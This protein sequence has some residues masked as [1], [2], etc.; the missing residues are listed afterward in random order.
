M[1]LVLMDD[2]IMHCELYL[3]CSGD[4]LNMRMQADNFLW[5][6]RLDVNEV[7]HRSM[8]NLLAKIDKKGTNFEQ[9]SVS[10]DS[11]VVRQE[12]CSQHC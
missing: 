5:P 9:P 11:L 7:A 2:A 10:P 1:L 4:A 6:L 12:R 8:N 3:I